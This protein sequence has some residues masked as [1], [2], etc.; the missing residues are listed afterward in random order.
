MQIYCTM[1]ETKAVFAEHRIRSLEIIISRYMEVFGIQ[2]H[3]EILSNR[4]NPE[5]QK[6]LLDSLDTKRC[7][8][9]RL[10]VHSVQR[11]TT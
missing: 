2:V 9:L 10:S 8:E 4:H 6:K 1:S 7:Q 5:I 3:S 11:A